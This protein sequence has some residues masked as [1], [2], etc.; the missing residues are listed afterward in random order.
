MFQGQFMIFL[1]NHPLIFFVVT[2]VVLWIFA[3]IGAFF[4]Q[5]QHPAALEDSDDYGLILGATLTLLG[6]LIGFTFSMAAG[7][8][9]QRKNYEEEEANAIGTE[10]VRVD[11]L[12][13][14]DAAKVRTLLREYLDVRI[15]YYS[16]M[17]DEQERQN[18]DATV[19][20]QA[21]LWAAI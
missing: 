17:T 14:A 8:Y 21:Q 15:V 12:P 1:V 4:R 18:N 9:D 6:L 2:L 7:R 11:L 3:H 16:R 19:K 20:L 10:Y 5:R 13:P